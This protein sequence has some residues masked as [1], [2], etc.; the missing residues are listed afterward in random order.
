MARRIVLLISCAFLLAACGSS[1]GSTSAPAAAFA[2]SASSA[3]PAVSSNPP[4]SAQ[5]TSAAAPGCGQYCQQAGGSAGTT[6]IG[7]PCPSNGCLKCPAQNC[8][9]VAGNSGT[10]TNGVATVP[11][12]CNLA[13][14]C[15]GAVLL[16]RGTDGCHT[17]GS[18]LGGRIAGS[19][20]TLAAGATSNVPVG[21]TAFGEQ[22][23]TANS[24]GYGVTVMIDMLDYGYVYPVT[25]TP[26]SFTV[27]TSDPPA[28]PSGATA[29]CGGTLF[30]GPGT[31]CPFAQNVEHAYTSSLGYGN[32][33][34]TASSPVTGETY[35]MQCTDGWPVSCSGGTNALV[36]FYA[37]T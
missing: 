3:G 8:I 26:P 6:T 1:A 7:Y 12:T 37:D 29:S 34:V 5:A 32:G 11:L 15:Q 24:S 25:D 33:T 22:T 16:C 2:S 9:T 21:L 30:V 19:D 23:V 28:Y 18:A 10:V 27:T 35:Q 4:S 17:G 14:A 20:F 31:S 36:E 13:T